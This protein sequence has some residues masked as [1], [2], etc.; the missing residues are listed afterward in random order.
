MPGENSQNVPALRFKEFTDAWEQGEFSRITSPVRDKNKE[1]L[2]F[3]SYSI[4]NDSGFVP[5]DEKFENG[6]TMRTAD[7]RVYYVVSKNTFAYNPARINV[8]SIG[9]YSGDK[10]VIVSSLYEVFKTAENVYDRFLWHWFKSS[11][12]KSNVAK[13]QE[14]GVRLYF[15]YDKLCQCVL[16]LPSYNEQ[17]LIGDGLD[18]IDTLI[19]LQQRKLLKLQDLKKALL[20][21]MFP[22]KGENVPAVRFKGFT[23]AWEQFPWEKCVNISTNMV[24]PTSGEFDGLPHIGPGNIESFTGQLMDN[25]HTVA[26]DGLISGK[27]L[28]H[29]GDIIYGK[30][31]PHLGKYVLVD[32]GGL[33]SA[34][35]YVLNARNNLNQV[36]LYVILQTKDFFRYSVSVSKRSGIPKINR[37]QLN[38]YQFNAPSINEQKKIG[39]LIIKSDILISFY[40]RKLSKLKDIK[41]ALLN[42]MFPGGEI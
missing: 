37:E 39:N 14:G 35:S 8:G 3:E 40:R 21:K 38:E 18:A 36:F 6:G 16:A 26:E 2:P 32:F 13:L 1:N 23:D 11:E 34:D 42:N 24:D 31:N 25:I 28:F 27:F 30:I 12:F 22:V 33:A 4:T 7:K 41:K 10:K 20:A 9:Y 5:Q 19:I 29:S 17:K 15:Y